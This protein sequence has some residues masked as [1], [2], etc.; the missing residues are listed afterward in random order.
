[1]TSSG[2]MARPHDSIQ[3]EEAAAKTFDEVGQGSLDRLFPGFIEGSAQQARVIAGQSGIDRKML[4]AQRTQAPW[5]QPDFSQTSATI[6][7]LIAA[8]P[9]LAR[10]DDLVETAIA[11]FL[12]TLDDS[13]ES[14]STPLLAKSSPGSR[15]S[16]ATNNTRPQWPS[17]T[18]S[19]VRRNRT[20]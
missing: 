15:R 12:D 19:H 13:S 14:R 9:R 2:Y 8:Q 1:M 11:T 10:L 17:I 18:D 6:V 4:L 20:D 5:L 16:M 7:R 3:T